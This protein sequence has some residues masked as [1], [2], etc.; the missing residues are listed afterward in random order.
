MKETPN[1]PVTVR[2]GC[3]QQIHNTLPQS[4]RQVKKKARFNFLSLLDDH[5]WLGY[6]QITAG[7]NPVQN[8]SC[9]QTDVFI[10][11]LAPFLLIQQKLP[12]LGRGSW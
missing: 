5:E 2:H 1:S 3:F 11:T 12:T 10:R 8:T 7:E 9:T 4:S 6:A